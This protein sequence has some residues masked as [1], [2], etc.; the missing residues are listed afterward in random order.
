MGKFKSLRFGLLLM[1]VVMQMLVAFIFI[2]A[3][4]SSNKLLKDN[5]TKISESIEQTIKTAIENWEISTLAY[6]K[7]TAENPSAEMVRAI[8]TQDH[9]KII[10]LSRAAFQYSGCDGMTFADMEGNALA[11]VT[12]P[13]RFGDNIKTSLA[14]ADAL[15]G[16]AVSYV[17]PTLNNGFSITAGVPISDGGRQI[18]VLFMS[19][20][21]DKDAIIREISLM[22]GSEIVIYQ[23]T[24]P[25][26]CTFASAV[27]E[28]EAISGDIETSIKS[29][30]SVVS[31][32]R[33]DS[34][35]SVWRYIP[36][37]GR[38]GEVVGAILSIYTAQSG[39]WV[40]LMWI[41]LFCCLCAFFPFIY[42]VINNLS[43]HL[44][45]M[46]RALEQI[47]TKGDLEFP[48]DVMNTTATCSAW[49]NEL[50][51]C[52]RAVGHL[53]G[54]LHSLEK[55]LEAVASGD[56]SIES[57]VLSD[58]DVMGNAIKNLIESLN[59]TFSYITSSTS[60]VHS[61]AEQLSSG[62]Q[63]LASAST[64]QAATLQELSASI[65]DIAGKTKEN[66]QR[67]ENAAE[68]ANTIMQNAEKGNRQMEQ[69]ITAVNEINQANQSISKV[70]KV[71][72]DIAF[73]TNILALNAAVEAA[74]AG[75]AGKGF[76]V[77]AEEVRN[78]AAKSAESAKDT[79][80]L[81][82]N[83]ME[84]AQLGTRIAGETATSLSEI[85][86]GISR[87]AEII[88]QIASSS[89]EQANSILQINGAVSEIT[90]VVQQNSATAEES[91]S[92]SQE[93]NS[94]A[95]V[96]ENLISGFSLRG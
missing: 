60:L 93:M 1:T 55:S 79:G 30:K 9:E 57:Q 83:S 6:A 33:F 76:A 94:Q 35:M 13:D 21:L 54:H 71:I 75:A 89:E 45:C 22:T 58:K 88:S 72:D 47:G 48:P 19:K 15:E 78:L 80:G 25:V 62:S 28:A 50:G 5:K 26:I 29:G 44:S 23:G 63:S 66:A 37:E 82:A 10:E 64:Q 11:R 87:S 90:Q 86:S 2:A 32:E 74:R 92:A 85:V 59:K 16:R 42:R 8:E 24:E 41:I 81:I 67:T 73:Q 40:I 7:I 70:I 65:S 49:D 96:L 51:V 61:G 95:I 31:Y 69:M 12:A 56:F 52:A 84:K 68:L 36:V 27:F 46:S 43:T 34:E 53:L 39:N 14:I 77:V 91:A 3:A 18:G 20:R 17:Y 4:L 38:N